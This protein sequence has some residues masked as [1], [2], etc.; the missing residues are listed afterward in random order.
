MQSTQCFRQSFIITRQA[1][2]ACYPTYAALYYPTPGQQDE[3]FLRR[4]QLDYFQTNTVCGG[5]LSGVFTRVALIYISYLDRCASYFLYLGAE[6]GNLCTVLFIRCR[7][8]QGQQVA[9]RVYRQVH[10]AAFA[11]FGTIVA[12]VT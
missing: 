8:V 4:R 12:C 7:D 6:F 3:A 11:T 9:E 5:S 10:F 2:E 1:A